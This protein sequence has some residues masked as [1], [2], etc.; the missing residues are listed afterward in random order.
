MSRHVEG[1]DLSRLRAALDRRSMGPSVPARSEFDEVVA[2]R[3]RQAHR[4]LESARG[5]LASAVEIEVLEHVEELLE[6]MAS[7][8]LSPE[9]RSR[10]R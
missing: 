3:L 2:N 5:R 1:A 9:R 7:M 10:H 6:R 4:E 8:P